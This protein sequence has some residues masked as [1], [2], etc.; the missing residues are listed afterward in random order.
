MVLLPGL[1]GSSAAW[2][3]AWY[4]RSGGQSAHQAG[5]EAHTAGQAEDHDATLAGDT[6]AWPKCSPQTVH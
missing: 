4:N 1:P 3:R 6:N 5:L 2:S